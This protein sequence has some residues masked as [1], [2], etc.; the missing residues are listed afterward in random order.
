ML[1]DN[2]SIVYFLVF[3]FVAPVGPLPR[4]QFAI[5]CVCIL[6]RLVASVCKTFFYIKVPLHTVMNTLGILI[7]SKRVFLN[8]LRSLLSF[9]LFLSVSIF[10]SFLLPLIPK[11]G[12]KYTLN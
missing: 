11:T 4:L 1:S 9:V 6:N 7:L 8:T 2:F 10:N 3:S 12:T 5:D